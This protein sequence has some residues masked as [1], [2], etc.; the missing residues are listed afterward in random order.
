MSKRG[1]VGWAFLVACVWVSAVAAEPGSKALVPQPHYG[2]IA[3]KVG[4]MLPSSHLLQFPLDDAVSQRAWTNLVNSFDPDHSFFLQGDIHAFTNWSTRIDDAVRSGDVT[5]PYDLHRIFCQRLEERCAAVSNLLSQGFTFT[6]DESYVWKRKEQPWPATRQEQDELWRKRV[7]NE[8]L[9]QVIGKELAAATATNAPDAKKKSARDG[10]DDPL[11]TPEESINKRY[12]QFLGVF[13][14]MD[15]ETILQRYLS[16]VAAA[17]DP[18]TDYMSPMRKEDFDIDMNLSLCGIGAQLRSED[19]TAK[20]TELLPGGPAERDKREIRLV[21]GDRIIGVGQGEGP[22]EDIVHWPLNKAV[23]KI[24]GA[25]GTKVVL[26][27]I[28]ASDPSGATTKR[29]DLVRDEIKLEEQAATGRVARVTLPDGAALKLG[30]VKLPTFY[31]TMDKRPNQPGFRS[32][33]LDVAKQLASFNSENVAGIILDLRNN[34]GGSLREA[35]SLVGLFVRS[36]PVVQVREARQLL[37]LPVPNLDPAIAFRR[38]MVVLINR[39]SASASEIVAGALQDYGRAVLVGDTQSH[40]KGTVQ[41][42]MQLGAERNG[43]MKVTTA[44][45]YRINGAS[46]QRKGVAAD[47]VIPSLLEGLDIGEDKLPGALPWSQVESALYV[48]VADTP[49]VVPELKARSA[50]RLAANPRYTR[51]CALS[52][53]IQELNRQQTVPLELQARRAIMKAE[54]EMRKLE[55]EESA[56]ARKEGDEDDVVLDEALNI[57]ADLVGQMGNGDLP[58]ET[59]G[60]LRTRFMRIFGHNDP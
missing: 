37:V 47:I 28:P 27:V 57:L 13:R 33:T 15:E 49:K 40:G 34:G 59:E 32:A 25:K 48:P 7:K 3:Q 43:S 8:Y 16:A 58:M 46:T 19:G 22:V 39:A 38:P 52:R 20:I 51:Y 42:V 54:S 41:T 36:G 18:H 26:D 6:V 29:V 5:L 56:A 14:D 24:R 60:D 10:D 21:P 35:V 17:Y 9:A 55:E 23:R 44:S 1:L 30:V 53:H 2:E 4:R 31:G 12:R 11:G 45:F 50:K